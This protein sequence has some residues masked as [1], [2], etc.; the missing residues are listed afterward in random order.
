MILSNCLIYYEVLIFF[1]ERNITSLFIYG[2]YLINF[3]SIKYKNKSFF[4]LLL[5]NK[6]IL[7]SFL[8]IDFYNSFNIH[9]TFLILI[10]WYPVYDFLFVS[11][12]RIYEKNLYLTLIN[13]IYI[14]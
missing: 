1:T 8:T 14:I 2:Y 9:P 3:V 11:L 7:I 5:T 6:F 4:I 12:N 10:L 13:L